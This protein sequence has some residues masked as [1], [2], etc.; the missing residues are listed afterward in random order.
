[1]SNAAADAFTDNF[2]CRLC[3]RTSYNHQGGAG[4]PHDPSYTAGT[5][6]VQPS[7]PCTS[8]TAAHYCISGSTSTRWQGDSEESSSDLSAHAFRST[9]A[10]ILYGRQMAGMRPL[11]SVSHRTCLPLTAEA[12]DTT[13]FLS[14]RA[15]LR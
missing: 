7:L 9:S 8:F 15:R 13:S 3:Q 14:R 2:R 5:S 6:T 12:Q 1:M 10:G 11:V 4:S